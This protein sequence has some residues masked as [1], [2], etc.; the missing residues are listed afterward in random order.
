M[1]AKSMERKFQH[2]RAKHQWSLGRERAA[3]LNRIGM[4]VMVTKDDGHHLWTLTR[5]LPWQLGHGQW[6]IQVNGKSGGIDVMRVE[7]VPQ[8]S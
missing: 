6:V 4:P 2:D 3:R 5:S 7:P 1:S 8:E